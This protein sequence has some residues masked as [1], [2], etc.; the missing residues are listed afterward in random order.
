MA[1]SSPLLVGVYEKN[2]LVKSYIKSEKTS[3][4]LPVIFDEIIQNYA[5][6]N[7]YF[8]NGPGSFMAIKIAYVFLKT[9]SI[10]LGIKLFASDGFLFNNNKP[11]R[12]LKRVYFV[13]KDEKIVTKISKEEF[14]QKFEL[15]DMLETKNF[16]QNCEPLYILPAV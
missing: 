1:L 4:I 11:I 14:E 12:A 3:Y 13:K 15:P 10:S 16:S 7:I 2:R 8:A 6:G 9:I 5:I